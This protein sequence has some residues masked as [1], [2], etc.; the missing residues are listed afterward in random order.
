[1]I[2]KAD[3]CINRLSFSEVFGRKAKCFF[4]YFA[5]MSAVGKAILVGSFTEALRKK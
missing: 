3:A 1:M 2:S 4:K 5:V